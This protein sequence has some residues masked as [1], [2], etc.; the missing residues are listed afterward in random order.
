MYQ[1][2]LQEDIIAY[3]FTNKYVLEKMIE[4]SGEKKIKKNVIF[5]DKGFLSTTLTPGVVKNEHDYSRK[6]YRILKIY[7]PKGTP[8][9]C[10]EL[11]SDMNENEILFPPNTKL[12]INK[13][14]SLLGRIECEVVI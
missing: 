11:I 10:L 7:V 1:N 9:V 6:I 8:C 14:N 5:W 4:W 12:R 2:L 13:I 3:R